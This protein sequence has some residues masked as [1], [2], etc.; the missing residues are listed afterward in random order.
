M[1]HFPLC[2]RQASCCLLRWR[3]TE[4]FC[5]DRSHSVLH[6]WRMSS[7]QRLTRATGEVIDTRISYSIPALGE[8]RE[9]Y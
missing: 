2:R 8:N 5:C 6:H 9:I 4:A 3:A 7:Y 1:L